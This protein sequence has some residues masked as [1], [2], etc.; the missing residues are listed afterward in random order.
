MRVF[1]DIKIGDDVIVYDEYA[2]DYVE[3]EIIIKSK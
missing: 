1:T 3:H 2:H